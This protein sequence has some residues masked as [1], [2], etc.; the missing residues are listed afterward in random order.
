[1]EDCEVLKTLTM[2]ISSLGLECK[3]CRTGLKSFLNVYIFINHWL[4]LVL[5]KLSDY[6]DDDDDDVYYDGDDNGDNVGDDAGRK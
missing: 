6:E 1:M 5:L 4:I 3:I 2:T